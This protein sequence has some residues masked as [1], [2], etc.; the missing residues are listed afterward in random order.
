MA[1]YGRD[2]G[3][4][5]EQPDDDA[6]PIRAMT[7]EEYRIAWVSGWNAA[8]ERV[9]AFADKEQRYDEAAP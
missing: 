2:M 6:N 7:A 9:R 8:M 1:R 4:I 5:A 3:W